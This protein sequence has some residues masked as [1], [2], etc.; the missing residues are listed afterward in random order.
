MKG[1]ERER[2]R[3]CECMRDEERKRHEEAFNDEEREGRIQEARESSRNLACNNTQGT[4]FRLKAQRKRTRKMPGLE[5][6]DK[7]GR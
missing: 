4:A 7:T 6:L 3:A 5:F 2:E 1:R